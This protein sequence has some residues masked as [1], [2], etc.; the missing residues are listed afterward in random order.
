M[1]T[2]TVSALGVG[3]HDDVPA[4]VYHAD[5]CEEPSLSSSLACTLH[6]HSPPMPGCSTAAE[7]ESRGPRKHTGD[8]A[9]ARSCTRYFQT[10]QTRSSSA[11]TTT[12][13]PA[14]AEWRDSVAA[15]GKPRCWRR[16]PGRARDCRLDS[17][18]CRRGLRQRPFPFEAGCEC[19]QRVTGIWQEGEAWFRLRADLLVLDQPVTRICGTGR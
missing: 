2:P 8:D 14:A 17:P 7:S 9:G 6:Y 5:P 1:S 3:L 13:R 11:P 16:I 10:M 18:P 19:A 12:I 15:S 4:A